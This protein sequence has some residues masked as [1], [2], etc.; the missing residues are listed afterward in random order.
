M[1][2]LDYMDPGHTQFVPKSGGDSHGVVTIDYQ[3]AGAAR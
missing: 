1:E 2:L 3:G